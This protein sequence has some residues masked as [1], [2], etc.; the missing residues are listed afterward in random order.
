MTKIKICG[1]SRPKDVEYVNECLP[2]YIGFVFAKSKRQVNKEQAKALRMQLS[3]QIQTVG[4]FVDEQIDKIKELCDDDIIDMIQLHG[5]ENEEY[6]NA[7]IEIISKPIIKAVR[8]QNEEQIL[9]AQR[10]SCDKLLLDTYVPQE[11]GGSGKE[12]DLQLIPVLTKP[13]FLAGGLSAD[14]IK[15]KLS[16]IHP[17]AVDVSSGVETKG[18]KDFQKI[19]TF[20]DNVREGQ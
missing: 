14:N 5:N 9:Q 7:L 3:S 17:Y 6:I 8:V 11:Y 1:I 18:K 2:E 12:L 15:D 20:I 19:S 16:K 10:L 4:V 13:Y